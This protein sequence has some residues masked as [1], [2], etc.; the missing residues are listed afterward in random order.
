MERTGDEGSA[1]QREPTPQ[2]KRRSD[3][4]VLFETTLATD[5]PSAYP[6]G[7]EHK[8]GARVV[9]TTLGPRRGA[10]PLGFETPST[11]ALAL[12][13]AI[14]AAATAEGLR[15]SLGYKPTISPTG[16]TESVSDE[17]ISELYDFFEHVY[18]AVVFSYQAIEAFANEEI[19]RLVTAPQHLV[20]RGRNED[21]DADACE[22]WL[23]TDEK[24]SKLLPSLMHIGRPT[25]TKWWPDFKGLVRVRDATIHLKA[26]HAYPRGDQLQA[27]FFHELLAVET[28][29]VYPKTGMT[30]IEHL[31]EG[32]ER[33][34][35]LEA[36]RE[37]AERSLVPSTGRRP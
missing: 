24:L 28:V 1:E 15:G 32:R 9:A 31:H 7:P 25:K 13:A 22:R 18:V 12:S 16:P 10:V 8:A 26:R 23:S 35:W 11:S 33:P 14:R 3:W 36:A 37:L 2:G 21:L 17:T 6:G 30:A 27:S 4:R 34:A 20:V 5:L 19:Q 29:G